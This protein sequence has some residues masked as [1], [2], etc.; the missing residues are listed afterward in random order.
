MS[1]RVEELQSDVV[2]VIRCDHTAWYGK[3]GLRCAD[4]KK[5]FLFRFYFLSLRVASLRGSFSVTISQ[6]HTAV[7]YTR[8]GIDGSVRGDM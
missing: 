4:Q 1:I 5:F 3:L 8:Y 6:F 2:A 7:V